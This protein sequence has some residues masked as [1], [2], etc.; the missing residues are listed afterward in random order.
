MISIGKKPVTGGKPA[1]YELVIRAAGSGS[2]KL[3]AND[4]KR[5]LE[6]KVELDAGHW[7]IAVRA[8]NDAGTGME[9]NAVAVSVA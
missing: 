8:A 4:T 6:E 1:L 3:L 9:S 7:E 5:D 2:W